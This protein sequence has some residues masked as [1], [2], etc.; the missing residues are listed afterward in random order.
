MTVTLCNGDIYHTRLAES[1]SQL[2]SQRLQDQRLGS[3]HAPVLA[4]STRSTILCGRPNSLHYGSCLSVC[5]S[6]CLIRAPNS[7]TRSRRKTKNGVI[8]PQQISKFNRTV[9]LIYRR[10][11]TPISIKIGKYLLKLRTTVFWCAFTPH[12]IAYIWSLCTTKHK[13]DAT[14]HH[15]NMHY[16]QTISDAEIL[17][18]V[19][20]C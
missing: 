10:H 16:I 11:C 12:S 17:L 14:S 15:P 20:N 2:W 9:W 19:K 4:L 1:Q 6:V 18:S 3:A 8:V 13:W 5:L 7:K